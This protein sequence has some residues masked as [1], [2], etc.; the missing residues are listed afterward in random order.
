MSLELAENK[1]LLNHLAD[2]QV[3]RGCSHTLL[4]L[5]DAPLAEERCQCWHESGVNKTASVKPVERF[6]QRVA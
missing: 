4:G 6:L 2:S 3:K 5:S 1:Q